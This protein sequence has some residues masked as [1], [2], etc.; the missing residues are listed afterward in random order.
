MAIAP[1]S[2]SRARAPG[3]DSMSVRGFFGVF[4]YSRRA[5]E[6]VWSTSQGL[7]VCLAVLTIVAGVL[8]ASVAFVGSRIV[9]SVVAAMRAGGADSSRVLEFV[10]LEGILVAFIAA[11][12]RGISFCQSLLRAQLGQRVNVMILEKALTLELQH[13]EDSEFYDKLTRARREASSRPLS[14]VM[15]TFGLVQNGISL[16]SYGTLL[17]HFS[18]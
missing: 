9:D 8:P 12:Q 11:A 4:K 1:P 13:F 10:L 5:I 15:R 6:L 14:L 18:P 17:A 3:G 2:I 16:V 7:T